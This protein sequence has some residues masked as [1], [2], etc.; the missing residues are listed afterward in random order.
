MVIVC[1]VMA[2]DARTLLF[3]YIVLQLIQSGMVMALW[4]AN[5]RIKGLGWWT[6]GMLAGAA[7]LPL[8]AM[9][10][11]GGGK[12]EAYCIP[13]L[14]V[15][16]TAAVFY[17]GA[18]RFCGRAVAW[19]RLGIGTVLAVAGTQWFLWGDFSLAGRGVVLNLHMA[20]CYFAT[21]WVLWGEERPPVRWTARAFATIFAVGAVV[22][23]SR[24]P[25]LFLDPGMP[26]DSGDA[27][28]TSGFFLTGIVL[29]SVWTF[30]VVMLVNRVEA[31]E[32]NL[33]GAAELDSERTLREALL[34]VEV[35]KAVRMRENLAQDLH[36]GIGSITANV[37]MLASVGT[38]D[39]GAGRERIFKEIEEMAVRGNREIRGLLGELDGAPMAWDAFLAEQRGFV[40]CFSGAAGI[41]TQWEVSGNVPE[42][43]IAESAAAS[44]AKVLREAVH[45]MV[46]HSGAGAAEVGFQ[47]SKDSLELRVADDGQGFSQ[48]REGG[49]GIANMERRCED[50]GGSF[51]INGSAEG[52]EVLIRIPL[53]L[54][55]F[56]GKR[57]K[58]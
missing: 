10:A 3:I 30:F 39:E 40:V 32:R 48:G 26:W 18:C 33:R 5:Q 16:F 25:M 51:T 9:Q 15:I 56:Q 4:L 27:D 55:Q 2:L 42:K 12:V 53:P 7:T 17:I 8:F 1:L 52:T 13:L 31:H 6:A 11:G 37:A 45:N 50:L 20:G 22:I 47:F 49:R 21:A 46:R 36:D 54:G 28:K 24:V 58:L 14:A 23:V 29:T 44:L 34:E 43:V 38:M 57:R 41:A 19:R 35:Q